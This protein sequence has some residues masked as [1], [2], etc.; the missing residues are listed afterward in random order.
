MKYGYGD[1]MTLCAL[2]INLKADGA[3]GFLLTH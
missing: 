1:S 2:F 3:A